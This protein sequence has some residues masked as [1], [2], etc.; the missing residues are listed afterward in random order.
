MKGIWCDHLA[1]LL[2]SSLNHNPQTNKPHKHNEV[3][4]ER[5]R[6][7]EGTKWELIISNIF[8]FGFLYFEVS[9]IVIFDNIRVARMLNTHTSNF[10]V[11]SL[12]HRERD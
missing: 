10:E 12:S 2:S 3:D 5:E 1:K 7:G 6:G 8:V 4:E 11:M 9:L